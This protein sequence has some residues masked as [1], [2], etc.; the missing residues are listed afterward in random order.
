VL[1]AGRAAAAGIACTC[2]P[3]NGAAYGKNLGSVV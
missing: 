1:D 2:Y 3:G